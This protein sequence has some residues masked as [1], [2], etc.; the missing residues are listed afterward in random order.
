[1]TTPSSPTT[2]IKQVPLEPEV[3]QLPQRLRISEVVDH[4]FRTKVIS[5]FGVFDHPGREA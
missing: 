4:P 5:R 3:V 1:M 2:T